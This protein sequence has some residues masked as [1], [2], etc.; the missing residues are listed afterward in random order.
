MPSEHSGHRKRMR[1]RVKNE[2]LM[3]F[4]PHEV[5]E[6]LLYCTIPRGDTNPTAHALIDRFGSFAGVLGAT[7]QELEKAPGIGPETAIF[8]S[9][10]PEVIRYYLEKGQGPRPLVDTREKLESYCA[11]LFIAEKYEKLYVIS[12]DVQLRVIFAQ[13]VSEG[14]ITQTSAPIDKI[15]SSALTHN[16]VCVVITHN[17]PGG[18]P[19]PNKTDVDTTQR[20]KSFLDGMNKP[21]LDHIIVGHD[22]VASFARM[23]LL[24]KI[25]SSLSI[26][27]MAAQSLDPSYVKK[28]TKKKGE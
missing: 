19:T 5:L 18:D 11:S 3:N 13:C 7:P 8:L 15:V 28:P 25:P 16:A 20:I 23:G 2:S 1:E 27:P 10:L 24:E 4:Q 14:S 6:Y 12:L 17:H 9:S 21:L 22:K 26:A